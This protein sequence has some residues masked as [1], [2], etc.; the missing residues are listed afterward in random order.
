MHAHPGFSP[1][2]ATILAAP[3]RTLAL[4]ATALMLGAC[5]QASEFGRTSNTTTA[6]LSSGAQQPEQARSELEKATEYWGKEYQK[7][8]NALKPALAYAKNLKAM[9][10]KEMALAVLQQASTMHAN[11]RELAS[12]YGRLALEAEQ[13]ALANKLLAIAD[14]P[15]KPD[16]RVISARGTALAKLGKYGEAVPMFERARA[17]EPNNASVLNNLAM[18]LA[19][20]GQ[21]DKAEEL[22]RQALA[23][24]GDDAKIKQNLAIVLGLQGRH[25]DAQQIGTQV[26]AM[27][28]D[29]ESVRA[30]ADVMRRLVKAEPKPAS[31][32]AAAP[33]A[34]SAKA[35]APAKAQPQVQSAARP[36]TDA[37]ADALVAKAIAAAAKSDNGTAVAGWKKEAGQP[38]NR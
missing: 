6:A 38:A 1:R 13:I 34:V 7:S 11:D 27:T 36:M 2:P 28:G 15:L 33:Q 30:N 32:P 31:V 29:E 9:G 12:E 26:A 16:W 20:N 8:P 3:T 4:L 23:Q 10:Q 35:Q 24:R 21:P 5:S 14:D 19:A 37:E 25:D 17:L 22:L 18:A